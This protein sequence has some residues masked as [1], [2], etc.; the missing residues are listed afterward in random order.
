MSL[1]ADLGGETAPF[2]TIDQYTKGNTFPTS[3]TRPAGGDCPNEVRPK[4]HPSTIERRIEL[5]FDVLRH[6]PFPARYLTD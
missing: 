1:L 3:P 4:T 2:Q 5:F 6:L